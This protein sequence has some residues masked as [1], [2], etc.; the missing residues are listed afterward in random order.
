MKKL[1]WSR[2]VL[3][4]RITSFTEPT[5]RGY[6][7]SGTL[8]WDVH[9]RKHEVFTS[10]R[11]A[12]I[13]AAFLFFCPTLYIRSTLNS[14]LP[15]Y[16]LGCWAISPFVFWLGSTNGRHQQE[17]TGR[18]ERVRRIYSLGTSLLS[19]GLAVKVL[20]PWCANS[21]SILLALGCLTIPSW[22]PLNLPQ[23]CKQCLYW[24]SPLYWC[25]SFPDQFWCNIHHHTT[26]QYGDREVPCI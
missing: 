15:T 3:A 4:N 6:R 22:F 14:S 9:K 20:M 8:K 1:K 18:E 23:F 16:S 19:H 12:N 17:T 2:S 26:S 13:Y 11:N 7:P 5:E 21:T 24:N 25:V 10:E